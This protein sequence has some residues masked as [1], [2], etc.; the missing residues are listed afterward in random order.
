MLRLS[1]TATISLLSGIMVLLGG[2]VA[3]SQNAAPGMR[4]TNFS[5]GPG[6]LRAGVEVSNKT[7]QPICMELESEKLG[8]DDFTLFLPFFRLRDN[9]YV[10]VDYVSRVTYGVGRRSGFL[11]ENDQFVLL[12]GGTA[13]QDISI[14][15][16]KGDPVARERSQFGG[17]PDG[18]SYE[19][20]DIMQLQAEISVERCGPPPHTDP[21]KIVSVA[22]PGFLIKDP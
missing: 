1:E 13:V 6:A 14:S 15:W 11:I 7:A 10:A 22:S 3:P 20:T 8:G 12:P 4:Y 2:C 16:E 9:Q 17:P 18:T 21:R 5:T 19:R